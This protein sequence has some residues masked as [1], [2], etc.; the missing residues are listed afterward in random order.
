MS[1]RIR[2][3]PSIHPRPGFTLVMDEGNGDHQIFV[4]PDYGGRA[5]A[6]VSRWQ[7]SQHHMSAFTSPRMTA[8][9]L[10]NALSGLDFAS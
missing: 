9:I 8:R 1:A 10:R 6:W 4:M 7:G 5:V 3:M 2:T